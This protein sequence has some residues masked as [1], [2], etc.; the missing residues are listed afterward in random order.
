[1]STAVGIHTNEQYVALD[2]DMP[3]QPTK[4]IVRD[5]IFSEPTD[6][7]QPLIMLTI[8][9]IAVTGMWS[10]VLAEHYVAWSLPNSVALCGQLH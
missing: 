4:K 6:P 9:G 10:G 3:K 2:I 1:M 7:M 8:M 5:W